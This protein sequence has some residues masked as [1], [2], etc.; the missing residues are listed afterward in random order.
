MFDFKVTKIQCAFLN[1]KKK[2]V[3]LKKLFR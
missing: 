3:G 1:I 2:D